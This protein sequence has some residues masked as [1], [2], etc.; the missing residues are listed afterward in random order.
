[1]NEHEQT[2]VQLPPGA[3]FERHF[4]VQEIAKMWCLGVDLIRRLF[5][6]EEGV[7]RIATRKRCRSV[8]IAPSASPNPLP[9]GYIASSRT[10]TAR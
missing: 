1:M 3:A 10:P 4:S 9:S 6:N 8:G 5:A 2:S 7:I